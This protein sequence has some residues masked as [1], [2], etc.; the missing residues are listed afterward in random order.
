MASELDAVNEYYIDKSGMLYFIS[1]DGIPGNDS[2]VSVQ[3]HV[4]VA[5]NLS[6][7]NFDGF[8]FLHA[9]LDGVLAVNQQ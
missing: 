8:S 9:R 7:V 3:D 2:V 4:L 6:F 1:P 5:A